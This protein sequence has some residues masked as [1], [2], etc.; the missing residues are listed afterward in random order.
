MTV[1]FW[2]QVWFRKNDQIHENV[3]V[4]ISVSDPNEWVVVGTQCDNPCGGDLFAGQNLVV[5]RR[6]VAPEH[7]FEKYIVLFS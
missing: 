5:D 7:V 4:L 2:T 3:V 1:L 6:I